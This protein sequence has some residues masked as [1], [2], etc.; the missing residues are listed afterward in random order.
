MHLNE[1]KKGKTK[2][3]L[4]KQLLNLIMRNVLFFLNK[5]S[6]EINGREAGI[7]K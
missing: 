6:I 4:L 3:L 5:L 1:Y 7:F 2:N